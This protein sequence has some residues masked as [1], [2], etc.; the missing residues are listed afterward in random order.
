MFPVTSPV[1]ILQAFSRT[2]PNDIV[3]VFKRESSRPWPVLPPES[4]YR[5]PQQNPWL[6]PRGGSKFHIALS[7]RIICTNEDGPTNPPIPSPPHLPPPRTCYRV[8]T[9]IS[10]WTKSWERLLPPFASLETMNAPPSTTILNINT[11]SLVPSPEGT[12]GKCMSYAWLSF[13]MA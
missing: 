12:L 8:T 4:A 9:S 13:I 7:Y 2:P 5:L 1:R 11:A 6:I 3:I 10:R